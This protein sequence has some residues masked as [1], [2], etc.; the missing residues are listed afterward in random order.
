MIFLKTLY[1]GHVCN[2]LLTL[3]LCSE[4][5]L[6]STL[7]KQLQSVCLLLD[8]HQCSIIWEGRG[9]GER[10]GRGMRDRSGLYLSDAHV[11]SGSL[12][13]QECKCS[14]VDKHTNADFGPFW[15]QILAPPLP[16]CVTLSHFLTSLC[17]GFPIC[18]IKITIISEEDSIAECIYCVRNCVQHYLLALVFILGG[19]VQTQLFCFGTEPDW[20]V[21]WDFPPLSST[22]YI[23]FAFWTAPDL[24]EKYLPCAFGNASTPMH[25]ALGLD[26]NFTAAD[27]CGCVKRRVLNSGVPVCYMWMS[28]NKSRITKIL[29]NGQI[30]TFVPLTQMNSRNIW[31]GFRMNTCLGSILVL[32]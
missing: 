30:E 13:N 5:L 20:G 6:H 17:L 16:S 21:Q 2:L 3:F 18:K 25:L 10:E 23:M 19:R 8:R 32:L 31:S 15:I 14:V 27:S 7:K 26:P 24:T 28:D 29:G 12:C 9:K 1:P 4:Q 11:T 22:R